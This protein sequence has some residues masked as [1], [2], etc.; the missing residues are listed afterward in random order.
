MER[1]NPVALRKHNRAAKV[2]IKQSDITAQNF[3][4]QQLSKKF[5]LSPTLAAVVAALAGLGP[6]EVRANETH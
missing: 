1:K 2:R 5:G 4:A 6:R 3:A